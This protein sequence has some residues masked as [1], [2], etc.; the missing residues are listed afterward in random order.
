VQETDQS[1]SSVSDDEEVTNHSVHFVLQQ[2]KPA[3]Q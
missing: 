1:E 2:D 3:G